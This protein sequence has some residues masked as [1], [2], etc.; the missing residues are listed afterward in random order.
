MLED[1]RLLATVA[2]DPLDEALDLQEDGSFLTTW[3]V[4][5]TYATNQSLMVTATGLSSG[6]NCHRAD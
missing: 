5:P 2:T 4:E 6:E 1:R 3:Y